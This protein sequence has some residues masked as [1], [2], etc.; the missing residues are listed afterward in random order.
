MGAV[1]HIECI[2]GI[3]NQALGSAKNAFPTQFHLFSV[4]PTFFFSIENFCL[5]HT[6]CQF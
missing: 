1:K 3:E 5:S 2:Q 6:L 4:F